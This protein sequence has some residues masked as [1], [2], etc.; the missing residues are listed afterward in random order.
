MRPSGQ[1]LA[2]NAL[3]TPCCAVALP[4]SGDGIGIGATATATVIGVFVV[5]T[6]AL[7]T[8]NGGGGVAITVT[9]S[10]APIGRGRHD[11]EDARVEVKPSEGWLRPLPPAYMQSEDVTWL[12]CK[13][14]AM[15]AVTTH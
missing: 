3:R 13:K 11:V 10:L 5:V 6:V 7:T 1:A 14:R 4:A 15:V 9:S 12:A 2:S 8:P